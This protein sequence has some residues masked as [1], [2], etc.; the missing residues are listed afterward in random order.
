SPARSTTFDAWVAPPLFV[1][2]ARHGAR[3]VLFYKIPM[4][5]QRTRSRHTHEKK[6]IPGLEESPKDPDISKGWTSVSERKIRVGLVGYGL[7]EFAAAF[8]FQDHPNVEVVAVSDLFPDRCAGLAILQ[9]RKPWI[10]IA[11]ALDMTV[12]GIIAHQ[13]ALK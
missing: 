3:P 4:S 13:S 6:S 1:V 7:C 10:D 9:D 12:P 8:G 2:G 11:L 5:L